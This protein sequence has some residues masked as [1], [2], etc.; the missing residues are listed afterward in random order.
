MEFNARLKKLYVLLFA[1]GLFFSSYSQT[2]NG[3]VIDEKNV[4]IKGALVKLANAG[5]SDT[6]GDD[7]TWSI[8]VPTGIEPIVRKWLLP[9]PRIKGTTLYFAVNDKDERVK[10]NIYALSGRLIYSMVNQNLAA[11]FYSFNLLK[12]PLHPNNYAIQFQIGDKTTYF[13]LLVIDGQ[14]RSGVSLLNKTNTPIA[15]RLEKKMVVIDTVKVSKVGYDPAAVPISSYESGSLTITLKTSFPAYYLN[16]P[17]PCFNKFYVDSCIPGDTN[18]ACRGNCRVANS[19]SPPEDA[20]KADLPK[21]FICPRFML[22]S[23]EMLQAAKDDAVLYGWSD[24]VN[25]PFNY[26][27]VG[28]DP[29]VGGVD[30]LQSSCCQCYQIIY[31]KPEPSSPQPPDLPYPKSIVV[32]SFNTAASG[33][34]GFDLFMGAGGYGAFNSCYK[35][36]AF[37][38][39]TK[40]NE[41]IYDKFPYQNPGSGGISFLRYQECIKGWPPT[42]DGVLSS[43]CQDIIKQMCDQALV[44]SSA[45]ITEDTRRSC[46]ETNQLASLYHQNWDVMV[47]RV[48]CPENLTRVTGCRLKEENLSL[49]LPK[50]QTPA[51]AKT[52][53]AFKDGY[54]TTTMQDCCKPTCAWADWTVGQ[55]LPVD[56]EW[57]SFYSCDKNGKPITK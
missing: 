25:P 41:F 19:C 28:H 22:Y 31:V 44:N 29:D 24:S 48:R 15:G 9:A 1:S 46:I 54:H 27:V 37:G 53:G 10:I 23:T 2:L 21:T 38:N 30:N 12:N 6:S 47:K 49:P 39:T 50:V 51:D 55:K 8:T 42:V 45:Q 43:A 20:S 13:R 52:N 56:G 32:Q 34:K 17:N 4:G 16:P 40:F 14:D 18:S 11:G 7:G 26:G 3:K 5:F 35:D 57:N 33:P 36:A